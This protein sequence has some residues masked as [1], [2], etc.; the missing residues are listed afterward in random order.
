MLP[1]A[2]EAISANGIFTSLQ[3]LALMPLFG[4]SAAGGIRVGNALGANDSRRASIMARLL[5]CTSLCVS[6][7]GALV[8]LFARDGFAHSY[9]TDPAT[10]R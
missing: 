1:N 4:L 2:Q 8:I 10:L 7:V 5:M 3:G 6:V 9:T